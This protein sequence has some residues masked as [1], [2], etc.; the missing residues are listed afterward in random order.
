MTL[1]LMS[2]RLKYPTTASLSLS[3]QTLMMTKHFVLITRC[4]ETYNYQW[5]EWKP[6]SAQNYAN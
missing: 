1:D 3:L 2:M 5:I 4:C 6:S